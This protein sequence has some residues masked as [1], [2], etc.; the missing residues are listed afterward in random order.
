MTTET[1]D[2]SEKAFQ[3]AVVEY[4]RLEGWKV[5]HHH[6]SRRQVRPGVL[7]GDSDA[8][9]VPDLL[10]VKGARLIFA[11][12]KREKTK[13]TP[14]QEDWLEALGQVQRYSSTRWDAPPETYL[15]RPRMW[16]E[17]EDVLKGV[18]PS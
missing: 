12:L 6:D 11:E 3:A 16:A 13:P 8:A 14:E 2:M 4:A 7:V 5:A 18:V 17:I 9:G 10:L 15:W 1:V